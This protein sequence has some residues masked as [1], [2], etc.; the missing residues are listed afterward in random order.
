MTAYIKRIKDVNKYLNAVIE[1]RFA[2]AI[3]DAKKA[4]K[5]IVETSLTY[6]IK[7]YPLLGVPFTIKESIAVKGMSQVGGSINR[8]GIK[9]SED[10]VVVQKLKSA[11]GI[12][13]LVSSTPEYCFSWECMNLV[14]GRTKNPY[15]LGRTSGELWELQNFEIFEF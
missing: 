1:E 3:N 15:D 4:D 2:D 10:A 13:L 11:G 9:A 7:N 8:I 6:V 14:S 5:I 12:P